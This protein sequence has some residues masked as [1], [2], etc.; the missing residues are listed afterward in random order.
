MRGQYLA[1]IT[2]MAAAG[3]QILVT[4]TQF[5]NGGDGWLGI[6]VNSVFMPRPWLGHSDEAMLRYVGVVALLGFGLVEWLRR[7]RP[8]RAWALIRKSEACAMAAGANVAL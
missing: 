5:A 7:S 1:I 2:L 6:A 3:F 8:G 4:G